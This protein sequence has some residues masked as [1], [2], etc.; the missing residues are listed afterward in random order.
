M[1]LVHVR[2]FVYSVLG[3]TP[4]HATPRH[5]TPRHATPRHATPRH[6]TPRHATLPVS[7]WLPYNAREV[8]PTPHRPLHSW[9]QSSGG[10]LNDGLDFFQRNLGPLQTSTEEP[11]MKA[12]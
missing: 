4:R 8:P 12:G 10:L 1:S 7:M 5:A 11:R 9:R 3:A 6:A 2:M